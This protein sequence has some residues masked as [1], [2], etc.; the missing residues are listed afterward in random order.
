[1]SSAGTTT[2][3]LAHR[4]CC[5]RREPQPLCRRLKEKLLLDV[6]VYSLTGIATRPKVTVNELID[7][8]GMMPPCLGRLGASKRALEAVLADECVAP[9]VAG[10]HQALCDVAQA[11]ILR[12]R[13]LQFLPG[14]RHRDWRAGQASGRVGGGKRLAARIHSVVNEDLAGSP[15]DAPV[16]GDELGVLLQQMASDQA[17][18]LAYR[19]EVER[20]LDRQIGRASCRERV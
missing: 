5:L 7:R 20:A 3:S 18:D 2:S 13:R 6:A 4:Y 16:H 1:M 12:L 8:A 11:E 17:R 14:Q 10:L 9:R 15:G 19:S